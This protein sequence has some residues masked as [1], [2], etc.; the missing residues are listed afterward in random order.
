M[1]EQDIPSR[2]INGEQYYNMGNAAKYIG[3]TRN[4]LQYILKRVKGTERE[5]PVWELGEG[6]RERLI[7]KSDLDRYMQPRPVRAKE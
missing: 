5:I 1:P 6:S 2:W 4:G 3:I 7:K